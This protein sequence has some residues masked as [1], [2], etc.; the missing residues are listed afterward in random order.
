MLLV[1]CQY[2]GFFLVD[3]TSLDYSRLPPLAPPSLC[4]GFWKPPWPVPLPHI[5]GGVFHQGSQVACWH[6]LCPWPPFAFT[7][8][9]SLL[10]GCTPPPSLCLLKLKWCHLAKSSFLG[11]LVF[12]F[13]FSPLGLS[14]V[15]CQHLWPFL[16]SFSVNWVCDFPRC[17][18]LRC[19]VNCWWL[20]QKQGRPHWDCPMPF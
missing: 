3:V 4:S 10:S 8:Q 16:P 15:S 20:F 13:P 2:R 18:V 7:P 11:V 17:P 19:H 1:N 9:V 14:G 6:H 12:F 5:L